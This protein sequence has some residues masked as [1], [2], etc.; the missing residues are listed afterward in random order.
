MSKPCNIPNKNTIS[1]YSGT[2]DKTVSVPTGFGQEAIQA[3]NKVVNWPR[4]IEA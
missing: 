4:Y 3:G 2:A 1:V